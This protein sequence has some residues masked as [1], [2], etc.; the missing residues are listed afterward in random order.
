[1]MLAFAVD[2]RLI[3]IIAADAIFATLIFRQ[4][5]RF[6]RHFHGDYCRRR[7]HYFRR[8]QI[9]LIFAFRQFRRYYLRR[10]FITPSMAAFLRLF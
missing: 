5:R 9:T 6:R 3:I 4:L 1:M 7:R 2:M 8:R 10:H